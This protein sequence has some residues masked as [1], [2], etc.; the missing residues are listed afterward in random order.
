MRDTPL[1]K[2]GDWVTRGKLLGFV[3]S[4]GNSSGPHLH[5]DIRK[6]DAPPISHT[7]YTYGMNRNQVLSRYV[8]PSPFIKVGIPCDNTL[9]LSGYR[10]MQWTGS[11]FHPGIDCNSLNDFGKPI[12]APADGRVVYM[13]GTNWVKNLFGKLVG[14]N[15]NAGWGNMIVIEIA[16]NYILPT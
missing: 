3:G 13:V 12:Y 10:F 8:D 9:P 2:V 7:E 15:W 6:T 11:Y 5:C 4:T 16:P 1:V 14:K